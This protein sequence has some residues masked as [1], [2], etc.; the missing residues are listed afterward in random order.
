MGPRIERCEPDDTDFLALIRSLTA[1][2]AD[3]NGEKDSFYAQFNSPESLTGAV[4]G[5]VDDVAVG[6]GGFR[7]M[8]VGTVE[9]KRMFVFPDRRGYG[10][11]ASIFAELERWAS[12]LGHTHAVMETSK[13][14]SSAVR[15]Y[16]KFGYTIIDNYGP[17]IGV[18]DSVCM[19][20]V[21]EQGV[22]KV[23]CSND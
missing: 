10:I 12:E 17:Y 16:Q 21:I 1:M 6:C 2:L 5:Y 9:I 13:R 4:V 19:E 11:G 22:Q 23:P 18:D 7:V 20:K 15:L 3:L 14:L 8:E